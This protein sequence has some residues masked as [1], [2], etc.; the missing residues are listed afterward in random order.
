MRI[1]TG[2]PAVLAVL[3][4][5]TFAQFSPSVSGQLANAA[6]VS[7]EAPTTAAELPP[8]GTYTF[9]I[10]VKDLGT[11]GVPHTIRLGVEQPT[12]RG[13]VASLD[14]VQVITSGGSSKVV[15]LTVSADSNP[16]I[17][18]QI[19]VRA[20]TTGADGENESFI[21]FQVKVL[22]FSSVS[23]AI[24]NPIVE[25]GQDQYVDVEID[26]LNTGNYMDTFSLNVIDPPTGWKMIFSS[27]TVTIP[28]QSSANVTLRILTPYG[29]F[30]IT[31]ESA[32]IRIR[33]N[34]LTNPSAVK[35]D[36]IIV[37]IRGFYVPELFWYTYFP[38]IILAILIAVSLARRQ[39]KKNRKET[40]SACGPK[41]KKRTFAPEEKGRL[42]KLKKEKPE[43]YDAFIE[44]QDEEYRQALAKY[45]ACV[46]IYGKRKGLLAKK[47]RYEKEALAQ[48][49]REQKAI[50]S[51]ER[52]IAGKRRELEKKA[53]AIK[54]EEEKKAKNARAADEKKLAEE[55]KKKAS[56]LKK[57]LEAKKKRLEK[58]LKARQKEEE[59]QRARLMKEIQKKRESIRKGGE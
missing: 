56:Q 21:S 8:M 52:E 9:N 3:L 7:L 15:H 4:I 16:S 36:L 6:A 46:R 20:K 49:R 32:I 33:A 40:E 41:P 35:E 22:Q 43:L 47:K 50:K 5:I 23:M 18:S 42:D 31:Q 45:N 30:Y 44:K 59:K 12:G 55:N 26:V 28:P 51:K 10:T 38:L 13:W 29:K 54:K 34:S 39:H 53:V 14:S 25:T 1:G 57:Q 19:I 37:T 11:P 24:R 58:L 17:V 48:K 2:S 27:P